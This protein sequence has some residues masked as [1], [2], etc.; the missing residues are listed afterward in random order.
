MVNSKSDLKG[1]LVKQDKIEFNSEI[2][3]NVYKFVPSE[4]KYISNDI[5]YISKQ[6]RKKKLLF[7]LQYCFFQ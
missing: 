2:V 6:K 7:I 4:Q 3:E 5:G 1:I